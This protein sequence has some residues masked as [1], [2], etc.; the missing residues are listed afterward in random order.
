MFHER[1][2]NLEAAL[3]SA[4]AL[5][6]KDPAAGKDALLHVIDAVCD[7]RDADLVTGLVYCLRTGDGTIE[8]QAAVA[9]AKMADAA[10]PAVPLLDRKSTRL[11]SSH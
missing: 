5:H 7:A 1:A 11:N 8:A 3:Y 6:K 2:H 4:L 9:L 10:E